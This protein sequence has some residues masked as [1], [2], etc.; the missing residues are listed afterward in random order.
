MTASILLYGILVATLLGGAAWAADRAC[1]SY[2]PRRGIWVAALIASLVLPTTALVIDWRVTASGGPPIAAASISSEEKRLSAERVLSAPLIVWRS[3]T[4]L[5]VPLS[6]VW[7]TSSGVLLL[8]YVIA[9]CRLRRAVRR[10]HIDQIEGY[11][12]SAT[13]HLGPAVFG[14]WSPRI[15]IPTWVLSSPPPLSHY[16]LAHEQEHIDAGDSALWIGALL[17]VAL[18][19]WNLPLWWQLRRLRFAIEADCDA[20]VVKRTGDPRG[21]VSVLMQVARYQG[22]MQPELLL[23]PSVRGSQLERRIELLLSER[24]SK[25]ASIRRTVPFLLTA[26]LCVVGY[27]Q[28]PPWRMLA[29]S[30][31]PKLPE[32]FQRIEAAMLLNHPEL[33]LHETAP[34]TAVTVVMRHDGTLESSLVRRANDGLAVGPAYTGLERK[35]TSYTGITYIGP[36]AVPVHFAGRRGPRNTEEPLSILVRPSTSELGLDHVRCMLDAGTGMVWTFSGRRLIALRSDRPEND[37]ERTRCFDR[38]EKL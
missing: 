2:W 19:P 25:A 24:P 3:A 20:R 6:S 4:V 14:C 11:S 23:G 9:W 32:I 1:P 26:S 13:E 22:S 7:A 21:H 10:C 8:V 15:L 33:F 5:D 34:G 12:I 30:A 16:V 28:V 38:P 18:T 17:L 37:S 31:E 29:Q 27:T 36:T 35:E